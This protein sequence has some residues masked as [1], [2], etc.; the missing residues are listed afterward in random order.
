[1]TPAQFDA[2][3]RLLRLRPGP[4]REC[5]RLVLVDGLRQVDAMAVTGL[6]E[7]GASNAVRRVQA[8][9]ELARVA[10]GQAN[11]CV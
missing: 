1:M 6:S 8:G 11:E 10:A 9:L 4:A 7:Q 5:A 2:L 3:S